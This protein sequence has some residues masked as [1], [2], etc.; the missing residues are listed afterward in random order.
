MQKQHLDCTNKTVFVGSQT[1]RSPKKMVP[2]NPR[3]N[4][5]DT[6]RG[7]RRWNL[8]LRGPFWRELFTLIKPPRR[9]KSCCFQLP[10]DSVNWMYYK[11][12]G[13]HLILKNDVVPHKNLTPTD[14]CSTSTALTPLDRQRK[15]KMQEMFKETKPK[16]QLALE[17]EPQPPE[18]ESTLYLIDVTPLMQT[19]MDVATIDVVSTFCRCDS[20]KRKRRI[21]ASYQLEKN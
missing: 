12:I 19:T 15:R 7:K 3:R 13:I 6:K 16:P 14:E 11:T 1:S 18:E 5:H 2:E 4:R 17:P 20:N 8:L 9:T 10:E 21:F